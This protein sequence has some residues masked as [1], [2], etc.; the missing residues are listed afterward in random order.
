M[1]KQLVTNSNT[2]Y[3][4]MDG[5]ASLQ[6]FYPTL[7]RLPANVCNEDCQYIK[8]TNPIKS[9]TSKLDDNSYQAI[10]GTPTVPFTK[11][12]FIKYCP[13][14]DPVLFLTGEIESSL[15]PGMSESK[16]DISDNANN[17]AYVDSTFVQ[18]AEV[19]SR[20]YD[21]PNVVECHGAPIG[22]KDCFLYDIQDDIDILA[23][24]NYFL[25]SAGTIYN[26]TSGV[27]AKCLHSS[28]KKRPPINISD[29]N[30]DVIPLEI[31]DIQET[32][33]P[34][35][36]KE[37]SYD[38]T[39]DLS[40]RESFTSDSSAELSSESDEYNDLE[41][42]EDTQ[43]VIEIKDFAVAAV[44]MEQLEGTL[45]SL[46]LKKKHAM[47][48]GEL[49]A[50]LM[51]IIMSLITFQ[52]TFDLT[53][54][55]LHSSNI[56][57]VRTDITHIWYKYSGKFYKVPTFG[58]IWKIIDFGRSIYRYRDQLFCSSSFIEGGD[59]W[60][61]YN[62]GPCY[63]KKS[64]VVPPNKSFDLCRLAV[65]LLDFMDMRGMAESEV[66][67][68]IAE[69]CCSDD[70]KNIL[71]KSNGEERYPDF[72]LYKMIARTVTKHLPEKQL[73]RRVFS[74]FQVH[75]HKVK[76]DTSVVDLDKIVPEFSTDN[77]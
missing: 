71:Y 62:F 14:V 44:I 34:T 40:S 1:K 3:D 60:S 65:S 2:L 10:I 38:R 6:G 63:D 24:N 18:L 55:D 50:A 37:V 47:G 29:N 17:S 73:E 72:K 8:L 70:G 51:Q 22:T 28:P 52:K 12:V 27:I 46:L 77:C 54:N 11:K 66:G 16:T 32:M 42:E 69:W 53:H 9:I 64:R 26:D 58:K 19:L 48:E 49:S 23:H 20:K 61:Q 67:K 59:A 33:H 36:N 21:L 45:D 43:I 30:E 7:K 74:K 31:D 13:I 39:S 75:E 56:M 68:T 25:N 76:K 41:D 5:M 35:N 4:S 15:L 57:F